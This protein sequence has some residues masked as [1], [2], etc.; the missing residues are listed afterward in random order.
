MRK[1]DQLF[2]RACKSREPRV[3]LHSLYKRFYLA[4]D[5][6]YEDREGSIG[7]I[8]LG[9]IDKHFPNTKVS[10]VVYKMYPDHYL[11]EIGESYYSRVVSVCISEIRFTKIYEIKGLSTPRRFK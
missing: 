6:S 10:D 11:M 7:D 3:R 4:G 2:I 5:S 1:I 9:I 8:L